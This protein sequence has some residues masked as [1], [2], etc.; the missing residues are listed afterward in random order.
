MDRKAE[1][2]LKALELRAEG[3]RNKEISNMTGFHVQYI[4]ILVSRYKT[5]GL[6]SIAENHYP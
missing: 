5:Q 3:K 4:T 2:R 1:K 6:E